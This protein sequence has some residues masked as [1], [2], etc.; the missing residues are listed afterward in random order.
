MKMVLEDQTKETTGCW[1]CYRAIDYYGWEADGV[2]AVTDG[3]NILEQITR[4][5]T[6]LSVILW[7]SEE[8]Y[9]AVKE[10]FQQAADMGLVDIVA[11]SLTSEV[12]HS[13]ECS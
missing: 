4:A 11:F 7:K 12:S 13:V 9:D 2:V 5:K 6:L 3:T 10:W 8:K 1:D